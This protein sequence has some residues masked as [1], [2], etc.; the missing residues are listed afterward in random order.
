MRIYNLGSC[1]LKLGIKQLKCDWP[2]ITGIK[3]KL[4]ITYIDCARGYDGTVYK[5]ANWQEIGMSAGKNYNKQKKHDYKPSRKKTF[6]YRIDKSHET[7]PVTYFENQ[8]L[9]Q[10][11]TK[12]NQVAAYNYK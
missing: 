6:I 11:V 8:F 2:N 4:L 10:N 12:L 5:A 3:P 7:N 1:V 9:R